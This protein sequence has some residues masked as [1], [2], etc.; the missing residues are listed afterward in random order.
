M[1]TAWSNALFLLSALLCVFFLKTSAQSVSE[2]YALQDFANAFPV[3]QSSG[4]WNV[5]EPQKACANYWSGVTCNRTTGSVTGLYLG[6]SVSGPLPASIANFT[7]L[8]TFNCQSSGLNG[9][10]PTE[11]FSMTWLEELLLY[12]SRLEGTIPAA[13]AQMTGLRVLDLSYNYFN[14]TLPAE[15]GTMVKLEVLAIGGSTR[16]GPIPDSYGQL[17]ALRSLS[18]QGIKGNNTIP[19]SLSQLSKLENL[20]LSD[21][22]L[23]GSIP[24]SLSQPS[25][26]V[27]DLSYNDLIGEIPVGWGSTKLEQIN[28]RVNKLDGT[29]PAELGQLKTL[30]SLL[31]E[32]NNFVGP[33]PSSW[34]GMTSLTALN[35]NKNNLEGTI[36]DTLSQ[37][38]NLT[39]IEVRE[40][41]M[42]GVLPGPGVWAALKKLDSISL[43]RNNFSGPL[44]PVFSAPK[45]RFLQAESNSFEGPIDFFDA[46]PAQLSYLYA[47]N[48]QL[49]GTIPPE[50]GNLSQVSTIS[51]D[52]NRLTGT[53]PD[54]IGSG[55]MFNLINLDLGNNLLQGDVPFSM[56]RL[57]S[58]SIF[59]VSNNNLSYCF[60]EP[61]LGR[62]W[63]FNGNPNL[64]VC[65]RV[66][67][68]GNTCSNCTVVNNQTCSLLPKPNGFP[69]TVASR[70]ASGISSGGYCCAS[71]CN[72]PCQ[73][74]ATG[75][76]TAVPDG[77]SPTCR[78]P[79]TGYNVGWVN[80]TCSSYRDDLIGQCK[81]GACSADL[82]RCATES[83]VASKVAAGRTC[84]SEKCRRVEA[85]VPGSPTVNALSCI[86][87]TNRESP[88]QFFDGTP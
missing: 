61:A 46:F 29:L 35:L 32:D 55:K 71:E 10:L 87:N 54:S 12:G 50:I 73:S 8:R 78:V 25:L 31:L 21:A 5:S 62:Y 41:K 36:P 20:D 19:A 76:C 33:I 38:G 65:N 84:G 6:Y 14:G 22:H 18:I 57:I 7:N 88:V 42:S 58:L 53:I 1:R 30:K 2:L 63:N 47:Q 39:S 66:S 24:P 56:Q 75:T 3:L 74:C 59:D 82:T 72:N 51:L 48:N 23:I 26:R 43:S 83:R 60:V 9:T 80:L 69:T 49:S 68:Q 77:P 52:S 81:N 86:R 40:N 67:I 79:C 15:I 64:C 13:I 4:R 16:Y 34:G 44:N 85:C 37:L 28:L 70:C 27:V 45:L 17:A 11:L